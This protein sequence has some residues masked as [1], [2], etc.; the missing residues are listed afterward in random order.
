MRRHILMLEDDTSRLSRFHDVLKPLG[1]VHTLHT[2]RDARQMVSEM[3]PFLGDCALICLDHD[4]EPEVAGHDPGDGLEV[5]RFLA[6]LRLPIPILIHS[7]NGDAVQRMRGVLE[8][9][10][11]RVHSILPFGDRWVEQHWRQWVLQLT[12]AV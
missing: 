8:L 3:S 5:A 2:W 1:E 10:G 12:S 6:P 7:S 9:E 4:L 11:W